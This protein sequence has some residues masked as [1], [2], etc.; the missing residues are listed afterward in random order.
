LVVIRTG[1]GSA[2]IKHERPIVLF[3]AKYLCR[4]GYD[5]ILEGGQHDLT[6]DGVTFEFKHHFDWDIPKAQAESKWWRPRPGKSETWR[7]LAAIHR[8]IMKRRPDV[9][10]WII[11]ERTLDGVGEEYCKGRVCF[12]QDQFRH[13]KRGWTSDQMVRKANVIL[14]RIAAPRR[15]SR[16]S[17]SVETRA[18]FGSMYH[19][20]IRSFR[21]G[22][23]PRVPKAK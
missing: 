14:N 5:V 8:D 19:F 13:A 16:H 22:H 7:I 10:V 1:Y 12:W 20:L 17:V 23:D 4:A 9:F 11:S 15:G 18:R 6:V 21:G 3:C 2:R